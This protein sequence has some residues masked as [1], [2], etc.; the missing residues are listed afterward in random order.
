MA[1]GAL[2]YSFGLIK[3][4]KKMGGDVTLVSFTDGEEYSNDE[5]EEL[6][7]YVSEVHLC[8]LTWK[9]TA[10][11]LSMKYP[12]NIRKYT[13]KAMFRLLADIKKRKQYDTV[14]IDHL[15]M[16]EYA[17]MFSECRVI[18]HTHNVES[19]IWFEYA[20]KCKRIVKVLVKRSAKMTYEY[21]KK[22][23]KTADYVTAISESDAQ[24][25]SSM[26]PE[27][28]I[29]VLRGFSEY[30]IIKNNSSMQ[31][32]S[33]KILFIGSYG[34]YPNVAAAKYLIN[35]VMPIL[36]AK[37]LDVKLYLVGKDPTD[38]MIECGKKHTDIIVTGMVD[39]VDPYI[40]EC[41]LFVNAVCEGSGINIKMTEAMG[42]GIPI[43]T[44]EFGARGYDLEN[45]EQVLIYKN[46]TECAEYIEKLLR[47]R[48]FAIQLRNNARAFYEEFN[49]P[50]EK[51]RDLFITK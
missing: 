35:E 51:V 14:I 10:L 48:Q 7:K 12:N 15:Q 27:K 13:R 34:W 25:F 31:K 45:G 29:E 6:K 16:F 20:K 21:E 26:V 28:K 44:S 18:L 22:A 37:K 32:V 36:R 33:K 24:K 42:K 2:I 3:L 41:D 47:D 19:D 50:A 39:S 49:M 9:S 43:V 30:Q 11:N 5:I 17:K 1:D 38:E 23:I 4:L 8:R 46:S 40:E